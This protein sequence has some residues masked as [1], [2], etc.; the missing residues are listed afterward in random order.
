MTTERFQLRKSLPRT[1][2]IKGTMLDKYNGSNET[3]EVHNILESH[4][5]EPIKTWHEYDH[6]IDR[7]KHCLSYF[8]LIE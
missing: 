4:F 1:R 7:K 3:N 6:A 8:A 5:R 2:L